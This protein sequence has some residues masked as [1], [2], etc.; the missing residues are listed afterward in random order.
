MQFV[1][2]YFL[3][4]FSALAIPII[5]HLF[6]FRRYKKVYFSN[7]AF[8]NELVEET[9]NAQKLKRLLILLARCLVIIF[10]VLAFAQPFIPKNENVKKG[11]TAVSIFVD[12]SF[13]MQSTSSDRSLIEKAKVLATDIV[14]SYDNDV[15]FQLITQS[16]EGK[17]QRLLSK[18]DCIEQIKNIQICP[19][20][21]SLE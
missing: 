13:S 10:L 19:S 2:P 6:N 11:K 20:S 8:L 14:Q 5:V 9:N 15:S 16:L 21:H 3:F 7:T 4:A 17:Q 12:N 18:D 1:N